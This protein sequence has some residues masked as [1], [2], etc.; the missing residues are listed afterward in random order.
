[1][2]P[3]LL[4]GGIYVVEDLD[5]HFG[6]GA[7]SWSKVEGYNAPQ[8]LLELANACMTCKEREKLWG[9]RRN[10]VQTMDSIQFICSAACIHKKQVHKRPVDLGMAREYIRES[11]LG[12]HGLLRYAKY[13]AENNHDISDI[14]TELQNVDLDSQSVDFFKTLAELQRKLGRLDDAIET[15]SK[16][17]AI[18]STNDDILGRYGHWLL[19]GGRSKDGLRVLGRAASICNRPHARE[20]I[21]NMLVSRALSCNEREVG[22]EALQEAAN[23]SKNEECRRVL[24][25]GASRLGAPLV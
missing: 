4:P 20:S 17:A 3:A 19:D 14:I 8:Y 13:M 23:R 16:G 22:V 7:K 2:F 5:F 9:T 24:L 25:N 10:I 15:L 18:F 1:M 6:E 21:V 11:S 12:S